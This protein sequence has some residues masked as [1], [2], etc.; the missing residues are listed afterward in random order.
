MDEIAAIE[1]RRRNLRIVFFVI[2]VATMPF[3][4]AGILLWGTAPAPNRPTPSPQAL[5]TLPNAATRAPT[6]TPFGQGATIPPT[7]TSLPGFPTFSI[8]T[9]PP[10]VLP[11]P[12]LPT[13]TPFIFP[14]LTP[15]PTLTPF[16]TFTPLASN[17][18]EPT[19]TPIPFPT[20]TP[21]IL[22]TETHTQTPTPSPT[23]ELFVIPTDTV[24]PP[25]T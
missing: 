15:A 8:A 22:P 13:A 6:F 21:I 20:D 3:Y 1:R 4:C 16:P 12:L 19:N 10:I 18:P 24:I 9:Q 2:I 11:P 7:F 14:T 25:G 17:T 23:L 5:A